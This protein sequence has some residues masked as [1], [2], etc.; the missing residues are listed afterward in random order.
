MKH[1]LLMVGA[2]LVPYFAS[3]QIQTCDLELLD[4]NWDQQEI[5]LT[6]NN[7]ICSN[8]STPSW[9][10][11]EDSVYVMQLAFGFGGTTCIIPANT[12]L[13]QP[14]LGLN[15]TI[16]YSFAEWNDTFNCFDAAFQYY[17]E[18]CLATVSAV[19][20]NNSINLD[21]VG[22]NNY[23]GFNPIW[24][25]CY[26]QE[27]DDTVELNI[28]E[29]SSNIIYSVYDSRGQF[30]YKGKTINWQQMKGLYYI[31]YGDQVKKVF[32]ERD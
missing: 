32:V 5:T 6:L 14:P 18:N 26:G 25:N 31:M 9:V 17:Q 30:L 8:S 2:C 1:L 24:E 19:G 11:A 16:T 23:I 7:N 29:L 27:D 20:P 13:F 22:G 4:I 28:G 10:P 21:L 3:S 15:D 12:T